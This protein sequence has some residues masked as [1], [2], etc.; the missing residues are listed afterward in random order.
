MQSFVIEKRREKKFICFWLKANKNN[1]KQ[2]STGLVGETLSRN[3]SVALYLKACDVLVALNR[4][5]TIY[6]YLCL[7]LYISVSK[8]VQ[9]AVLSTRGFQSNMSESAL[10][11]T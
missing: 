3:V 6:Q 8:L 2:Y 10:C 1:N 4:D 11:V 5:K 7:C 9:D